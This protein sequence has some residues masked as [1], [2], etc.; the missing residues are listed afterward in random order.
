MIILNNAPAM[1]QA[2]QFAHHWVDDFA[3]FFVVDD[4]TFVNIR[5]LRQDSPVVPFSLFL[6][7]VPF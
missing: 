3:W 6:A 2:L 4:D 5:N 7:L 1:V